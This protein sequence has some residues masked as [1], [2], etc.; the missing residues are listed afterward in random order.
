MSTLQ[1]RAI[2]CYLKDNAHTFAAFVSS[3][4]LAS[5]PSRLA[6]MRASSD[7]AVPARRGSCAVSFSIAA[8][9]AE[10]GIRVRAECE[11]IA[12]EELAT[13][14]FFAFYL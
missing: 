10:H 2:I 6:A 4:R 9:H 5:R 7:A 8:V 1:D 11:R 14:E 3:L 13:F 12:A